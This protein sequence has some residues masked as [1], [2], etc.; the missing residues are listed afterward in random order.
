MQMSCKGGV[1]RCILGAKEWKVDADA[2][3]LQSCTA[4]EGEVGAAQVKWC[5]GGAEVYVH[6][7]QSQCRCT[8]GEQ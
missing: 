6:R 2:K 7:C 8:I 4:S 1:Q 3:Q 5:R